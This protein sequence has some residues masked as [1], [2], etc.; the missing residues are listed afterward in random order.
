MAR[1]LINTTQ[2]V[3]ADSGFTIDMKTKLSEFERNLKTLSERV[4]KTETDQTVYMTAI[5]D[6][7]ERITR[8]ENTVEEQLLPFMNQ[9]FFDTL[10]SPDILADI[11]SRLLHLEAN[12]TSYQLELQQLITAQSEIDANLTSLDNNIESQNETIKTLSTT[13]LQLETIITAQNIS[14]HERL[15]TMK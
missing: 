8:V 14:L 11:E 6:M 5:K 12:Q 3:S 7:L 13:V 10:V 4:N 1:I 9:S 2:E 15:P